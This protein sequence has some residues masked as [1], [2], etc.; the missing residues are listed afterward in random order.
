MHVLFEGVIP[1][2]VLKEFI[3]VKKYFNIGFLNSRI[4]NFTYG[5]EMRNKPPKDVTILNELLGFQVYLTCTYIC[6][7]AVF[8]D[9]NF[10][11]CSISNVELLHISATYY[12]R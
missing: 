12:W 3:T 2:E 9:L 4:D 11:M 8:H 10:L 7:T 1:L 5:K 6:F